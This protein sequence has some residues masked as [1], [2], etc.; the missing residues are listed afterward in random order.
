ME[1]MLAY[2]GF[3]TLE[4]F[5]LSLGFYSL[6]DAERVLREMY[7]EDILWED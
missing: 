3:E 4:A 2:Y 1:K 5:G 6:G 7:E